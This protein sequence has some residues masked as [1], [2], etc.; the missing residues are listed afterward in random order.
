MFLQES[1]DHPL[2]CQWLRCSAPR[3]LQLQPASA[4]RGR[5]GWR[6]DSPLPVIRPRRKRDPIEEHI[7]ASRWLNRSFHV[8]YNQGGFAFGP[9]CGYIFGNIKKVLARPLKKYLVICYVFVI[10]CPM[11]C[12]R[13][14]LC[15]SCLLSGIARLWAAAEVF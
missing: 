9:N 15:C 12:V 6:E 11:I 3:P 8:L 7:D 5:I 13:A 2:I 1:D 4:T 10:G 14:A